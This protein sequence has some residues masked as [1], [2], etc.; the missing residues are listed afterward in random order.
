[1]AANPLTK[2]TRV[3]TDDVQGLVLQGFGKHRAAAYLVLEV[4]DG[5]GARSWLSSLLPEITL[6]EA[7]PSGVARNLALTSS[8]LAKL[9][10]PP[11]TLSGFSL[12]FL[13]GMTS[14]HR[15]RL[16]GDE[17][18][19]APVRWE[20][21]APGGP[22]VDVLLLVF[23]P[24]TDALTAALERHRADLTGSGLR[25]VATLDTE[26]IG[27]GEHFGF[28]DGLSQPTMSGV[29]RAGPQRHTVA[30]GE[31]LLGYLNEHGQYPRSPQVTGA[32][33]L[34]F[35]RNGSYLVLRTL[36]QD[37]A[38]FWRYVDRATRR[39]DGSP[40]PEARTA[41][42]ARM[43]GR[44]PSGAPLTLSPEVD[45]SELAEQNDF[46]YDADDRDGMRCP[47]GA[48]VRRTNPRDS[49]PP[50]PGTEA[51]TDVGKRHRLLRRGRPFGPPIAPDAALDE[52]SAQPADRGLHFLALCSDIARQFEFISH[53]WAM[54]P[55]F[56]GLLDDA[57]PLLG[58]HSSRGTSFTVQGVPV[59]RR[60]QG[61]PAFVTPRGGAYFFL[62]G[63]RALRHLAGS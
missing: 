60:H 62:P 25:E 51:S 50:K 3:D 35:G 41:L 27:R 10:L 37:V 59:R 58:G 23:A 38:G 1:M 46:G 5:A 36:V 44:W 48:H 16:L 49:L 24:D 34:D 7:R 26:D 11:A 40:D 14:A 56:A 21:G 54:N 45:R 39:P 63:G 8:G 22:E 20:W 13:E 33:D 31:F 57:D 30:P 12:E 32:D 42:A 6:G 53:T 28:R 9:G 4:I 15:S 55:A 52:G 43:V 2:R 29:G 17:G 19:A 18:A 61:V 47:V